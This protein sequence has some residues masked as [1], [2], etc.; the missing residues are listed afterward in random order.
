MA[1]YV[2]ADIEV[3]DPAGYEE[4][5][6]L[7]GASVTQYGGEY[8][9]RGA[10]VEQLEGEWMPHRFVMLRFDT[11]EAARHWYASP[12]YQRALAIRQRTARA[13]IVMVGG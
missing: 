11:A 3:T 6:L 2:I 13:N 4:Y 5:K 12:E 7:A 9:L 8:V 1:V 10:K